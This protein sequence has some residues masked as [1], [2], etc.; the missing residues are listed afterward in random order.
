MNSVPDPAHVLAPRRSWRILL[1]TIGPG[2]IAMLANTEAGSVIAAAKSGAEWGYKLVLP[3]LAL[4]PALFMAQELAGRLG[5]ITQRGLAEIVLRRLGRIPAIMLLATLVASCLGAIVTEL[6]G[7]AGAGSLF[8][9]PIWQSVVVT[10][11][12]LLLIVWTASYRALEMLSIVVGLCEVAF[13]VLAWL[14]HPVWSELATQAA[15]FPITDHGYLYLLAANLGTCII[16]WAL[17]YQQSASI[18]KGFTRQNLIAVRVETLIAAI[19]CQ[20]VT[21]AVV[22]A[23]AAVFTGGSAS[24]RLLDNVGDIAE[25][26]SVAVGPMAGRIVFALGLSSGALVAMIVACLAAA[27]SFGEFLGRHRSLSEHPSRSLWFHS[28]FT[29]VLAGGAVLVVSGVNLVDLAL[30]AGVLNALLL[31]ILLGFLFHAARRELPTD[32]RPRGA[33]AVALTL[34]LAATAG[35]GVYSGIVGLL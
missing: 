1:A 33:Y 15:A 10:T 16:P 28:A 17:L 4:V 5:L 35:L 27:W 25:A 7:I 23:A 9:L 12:A 22:V 18:D 13:V 6:S 21:A 34:V 3:Q 31:P 20:V 26:F 2:L 32:A 14:A 29:V 24:G 11:A 8:G 30:A 19:A